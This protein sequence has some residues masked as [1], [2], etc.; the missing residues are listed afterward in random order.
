MGEQRDSQEAPAGRPRVLVLQKILPHYRVRLFQELCRSPRMDLTL[1]YDPNFVQ[2]SLA[3]VANPPGVRTAALSTW[4]FGRARESDAV[5]YQR[6][7]AALVRSGK[8][9]AVIA[10]LTPRILSNLPVLRAARRRGLAFLWWGHGIGPR[11]AGRRL[12]LMLWLARQA[13]AVIFYDAERAERMVAAGLPSERAFVAPNSIDVEEIIHLRRDEPLASRHRVLYVGRLT[14]RKKVDLL[15]SAFAAARHRLPAETRL[16]IVGDGPE[17]AAL[18]RQA[19]E[20]KLSDAIDFTGPL[21]DQP[22]LAPLFNAAWAFVCAGHVGLGAVHSLAFGVPMIVPQETGHAPE[23]V[24]VRAGVNA[25][26]V[27]PD[28]AAALANALVELHS[29]PVRWQAFAAASRGA[30]D[31]GFGLATM[32]ERFEQAVA[33]AL[34]SRRGGK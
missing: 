20:L 32:V 7:A 8:F 10:P 14:A 18:E 26:L 6:G 13:D 34:R 24:N 2:S 19:A 4:R 25:L 5:V 12:K 9:D 3:S 21:Y 29:E 22:Q 1:G 30:I 11:T 33:F 31:R 17:R 16:T 28:D 23:I 27:P 15:L